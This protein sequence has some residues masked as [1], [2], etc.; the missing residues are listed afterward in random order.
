MEGFF[1]QKYYQLPRK[2]TIQNNNITYGTVDIR[3]YVTLNHLSH[4]IDVQIF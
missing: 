2:L 4:R 1:L 3:A